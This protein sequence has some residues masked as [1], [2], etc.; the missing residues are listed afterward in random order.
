MCMVKY[1]IKLELALKSHTQLRELAENVVALM[2]GNPSY[3][4][5]NPT[6]LALGTLITAF[7]D[8]LTAW[9][10]FPGNRGTTLQHQQVLDTRA[11]LEVGLT[12][13]AAYCT[14]TTPYDKAA[15]LS[16]GWE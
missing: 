9:G 3:S 15:F 1:L 2:S 14:T 7:G 10:S 8:A 4:T 13:L 5:P 11:D 6:L 12:T 16:A